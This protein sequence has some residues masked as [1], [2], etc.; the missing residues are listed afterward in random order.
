MRPR[1]V[2]VLVDEQIRRWEYLRTHPIKGTPSPPP[3]AVVV[4]SR[5]LGAGGSSVARL[6]ADALEFRLWD[7]DI[8][9]AIAEKS[10]VREALLASLDEHARGMLGGVV[11]TLRGADEAITAYAQRLAEVVRTI[12]HHGSAV[13]VGR[14]AQFL[15]DPHHALRVHVI[16]PRDVRVERTAQRRGISLEQAEREVALSDRARKKFLKQHFGEDGG[17]PLHYDVIV[18]TVAVSIEAAAAGIIAAYRA[19]RP[20]HTEV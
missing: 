4:V 8:V 1:S 14:G 16:A 5:E 12:A 15:V 6:V 2:E 17:E 13:I 18:N 7:R 11:A 20:P 19:R 9:H 3:P 10:G